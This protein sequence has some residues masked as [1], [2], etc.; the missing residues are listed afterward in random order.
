MYCNNILYSSLYVEQLC[1]WEEIWLE[2][3]AILGQNQLGGDE[4]LPGVSRTIFTPTV[5]L[6]LFQNKLIFSRYLA[7]SEN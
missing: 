1:Q 2:L 6:G 4:G 7:G 3:T 5:W